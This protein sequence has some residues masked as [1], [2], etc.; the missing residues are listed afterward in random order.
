MYVYRHE[1]IPSVVRFLFYWLI[2]LGVPSSALLMFRLFKPIPPSMVTGYCAVSILLSALP[3]TAMMY[4]WLRT[5]KIVVG[6]NAL[7]MPHYLSVEVPYASIRGVYSNRPQK[8]MVT[9]A[10]HGQI[11]R[12]F[13]VKFLTPTID[14]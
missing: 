6:A 3:S 11:A 10:V 8:G 7:V 2:W 9:I 13:K 4:R 5:S 12:W 14:R 1:L